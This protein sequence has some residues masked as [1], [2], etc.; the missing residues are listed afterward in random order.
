MRTLKLVSFPAHNVFSTAYRR[1]SIMKQLK[2][3][4]SASTVYEKAIE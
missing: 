3:E 2:V 4:A 1:K